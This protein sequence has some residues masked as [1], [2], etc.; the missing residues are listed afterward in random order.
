M[1]KETA[2]GSKQNKN[3]ANEIVEISTGQKIMVQEFGVRNVIGV[4][5]FIKKILNAVKGKDFTA[6]EGSSTNIS[7]LVDWMAVGAELVESNYEEILGLVVAGQV[8]D[9]GDTVLSR[10]D[11]EEVLLDDVI[12]LI[13][14]LYRVNF[15][16]GSLKKYA[17]KFLT[18][19][20]T[21]DQKDS[22]D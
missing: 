4:L 5:G 22:E 21:E 16:E 10:A 6:F 13:Q 7:N 11:L 17:K 18:E 19:E 20:T 14:A 12:M 8:N 3:A 9:S 2:A 15:V 1:G